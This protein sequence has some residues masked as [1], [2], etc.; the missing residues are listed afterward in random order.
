MLFH[1]NFS[2]NIVPQFHT[3]INRQ[4]SDTRRPQLEKN[5]QW[6]DSSAHLHLYICADLIYND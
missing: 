2:I 3:Q 1:L 4:F 6:M 5:R